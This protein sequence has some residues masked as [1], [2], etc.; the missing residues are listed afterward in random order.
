[1]GKEVYEDRDF[2]DKNCDEEENTET[3]FLSVGNFTTRRMERNATMV[4]IT[5]FAH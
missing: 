5:T 3:G 2:P 4:R 1:M